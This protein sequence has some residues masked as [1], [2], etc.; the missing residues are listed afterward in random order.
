MVLDPWLG[1]PRRDLKEGRVN[2][3]YRF[4]SEEPTP[5]PLRL[6]VEIN[7]REH[8]SEL[9]LI[10]VPFEIDSSWWTGKANVTTYSVEE[11]LGTKLR[12]LYQRKK[13]R[14]LF[15]LWYALSRGNANAEVT[16]RC[17]MR[18][19]KEEGR[20]VSHVAFK[21]NLS[22]KLQDR[23]FRSDMATLLRTDQPWDVDE[24]G[25]YILEKLLPILG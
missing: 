18:Y 13:G 15:D 20:S 9:G 23:H 6:K 14:D 25:T 12:A 21:E 22:L 19:L 3:V 8:F 17:F 10:R 5:K 4:L 2:L 1:C 7:S 24:A 16:I 11:L